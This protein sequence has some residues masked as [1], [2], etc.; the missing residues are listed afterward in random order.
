MTER[1]KHETGIG[2][3]HVP[4]YI[5]ATWNPTTG[6]ARV[7]P[8]CDHCYAFTL[9][10][11]RYADNL[12]ATLEMNREGS[13]LLV[14]PHPSNVE[15]IAAA[16]AGANTAVRLPWPKQYDVPFS[17]V[18]MLDDKRLTQPMRK[19][20]PRAYFV[21]SM[22]DLFHPDVTFE[23][24]D[25][26]FAVM[27]LT[28]RHLYQILTKRPERMREY[29]LSRCSEEGQHRIGYAMGVLEPKLN[30]AM[31]TV[32]PLRN[33][34]LGTSTEDQQRAEE[35]I[36]TLIDT[37]AAVH[38]ISA[39]PLLEPIVLTSLNAWRG[40]DGFDGE[41]WDQEPVLPG[42]MTGLEWVI[43]GGESGSPR[44]DMDDD[45]ARSL[46]DQCA[47]AGVAFYF[48]QSSSF[49]SGHEGPPDLQS[50][51]AFPEAR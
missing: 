37:P 46:R 50:A 28:P 16:R 47:A 9:H 36:P 1:G 31:P 39:E 20:A 15:L 32:W 23:F 26:V 38:F 19:Q 45:W 24:I 48:K 40:E 27:A 5:G 34:W 14:K 10:D 3:T 13:A 25:R 49:R 30:V 51:R 18:Q 43:V 33:V 35:R 7:S 17:T 2:W 41:S 4:G 12:R 21:D 11:Q 8:G 44:R 22:A 42:H 6:C 29:V